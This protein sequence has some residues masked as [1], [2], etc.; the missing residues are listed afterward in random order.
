MRKLEAG[1][2]LIE[3]IV[4][5][6]VSFILLASVTSVFVSQTKSYSTYSDIGEAQQTAKAI[7]DVIGREIR[8][9]GAGLTD[10]GYKFRD[11]S[12]SS[13]A[14]TYISS[15]NSTTG[16]D[17]MRIRGNFQGVFGV[18]SSTTIT[19]GLAT[20][21]TDIGDTAIRI[22]YRESATF[23]AGNYITINDRSNSEIRKV[24]AK[25]ATTVSF[26]AA[27]GMVYSHKNGSFFNGIQELRYFI[28]K[29]KNCDGT[30]NPGATILCRNNFETNGNQPVMDNVEEIQFQYGVDTSASP[31]GVIDAWVNAIKDGTN[32]YTGK[33]KAVKIWLLVRGN[34]PDASTNDLKTYVMG[35]RNYTPAV[36]VRKY[37]RLLFTTVVNLRNFNVETI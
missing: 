14:F 36:A 31:D 30:A 23:S 20:Y 5:I 7:L 12:A 16:A 4:V 22:V 8:M 2:T 17:A 32:D 9:A 3:L 26:N 29:D 24:T 28:S 35:D 10:K 25:T 11:G 18:I 6:G 1:F 19:S 13:T 15:I 34:V 21:G 27:E 37:K 33:V